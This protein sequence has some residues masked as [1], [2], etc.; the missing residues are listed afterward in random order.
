LKID[1]HGKKHTKF[2]PC[3][4]AR[5]LMSNDTMW[6]NTIRDSMDEIR[7]VTERIRWFAL[8]IANVLPNEPIKL[9]RNH[10]KVLTM[11]ADLRDDRS[12]EERLLKRIEFTLRIHG[13]RPNDG[14][15]Y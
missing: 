14:N 1:Q 8:F 9:L 10:F 15:N 2:M 13:I 12:K 6:D 11:W 4:I 7:S 5:G 3:A